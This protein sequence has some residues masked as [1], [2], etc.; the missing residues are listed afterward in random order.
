MVAQ[1]LL[2]QQREL[3]PKD[4]L[5]AFAGQW[6]VL[7]RGHVVAHAEE[8]AELLQRDVLTDRDAVIHV[9]PR[10]VSFVF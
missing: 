7:R 1:E 3:A 9:S 6:V 4:D 2:Y 8:M 10:T 5:T